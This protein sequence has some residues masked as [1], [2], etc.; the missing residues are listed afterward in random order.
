MLRLML[1]AGCVLGWTSC[2]PQLRDN[3]VPSDPVNIHV[4]S[5]GENARQT[6]VAE[7]RTLDAVL[8]LNI[9]PRTRSRLRT[10]G[11]KE[12][13]E[14]LAAAG[15]AAFQAHHKQKHQTSIVPSADPLV[16][17]GGDLEAIES[18]L[19]PVSAHLS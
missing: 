19:T 4:R 18:K 8:G 10:R 15:A 1:I 13:A 5:H 16:A 9:V 3:F 14:T 12:A 17:V 7:D 11:P 2:T 6:P